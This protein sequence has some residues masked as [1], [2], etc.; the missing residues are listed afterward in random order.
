MSQNLSPASRYYSSFYHIS[1]VYNL[2]LTG[3]YYTVVRRQL[4]RAS[5]SAFI[6]TDTLQL[7]HHDIRTYFIQLH[8]VL[9][10][11]GRLSSV[12]TTIWKR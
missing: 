9:M 1:L 3:G 10:L 12:K 5:R 11:S 7:C 6:R 4:R 2:A 8:L